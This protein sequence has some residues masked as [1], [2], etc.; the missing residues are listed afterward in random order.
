LCIIEKYQA[1]YF[2]VLKIF[3]GVFIMERCIFLDFDGVLNCASWLKQLDESGEKFESFLHRT[4][5]ELDPA[6]VKMVSDLAKETNSGIIISSSWRN[7]HPLNEL[8]DILLKNGMDEDVLPRGITPNI[9][10]FRGNEVEYWIDH[11]TQITSHVIFDDGTD[12]HPHQPLVLTT[13]DE[14]LLPAHIEKARKILTGQ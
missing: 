8:C 7:L 2:E 5:K 6:R 10:L 11:N 12:F 14:G 4:Y 9:G 13:W 1:V 3:I